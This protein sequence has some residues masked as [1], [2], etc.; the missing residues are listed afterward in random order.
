MLHT[1]ISFA[2]H[3]GSVTARIRKSNY[4]PNLFCL[5][6]SFNS[7]RFQ[8]KFYIYNRTISMMDLRIKTA[9]FNHILMFASRLS[10]SLCAAS[11]LVPCGIQRWKTTNHGILRYFKMA[12]NF[13]STCKILSDS[14]GTIWS[15]SK[16]L[17][18][19]FPMN[20]W[21]VDHVSAHGLVSRIWSISLHV[22]WDLQAVHKLHSL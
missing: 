11:W 18:S 5:N 14:S 9:W 7:R 4:N 17:S 21:K 3:S 8:V 13:T 10:T 2:F 6:Y 16:K 1:R 22:S 20:D 15:T 19:N 12:L